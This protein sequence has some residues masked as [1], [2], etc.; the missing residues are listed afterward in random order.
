MPDYNDPLR[1]FWVCPVCDTHFERR[2][3]TLTDVERHIEKCEQV[4]REQHPEVSEE[5]DE[6]A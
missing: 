3:F 4:L 2:I 1:G 6:E 5:T